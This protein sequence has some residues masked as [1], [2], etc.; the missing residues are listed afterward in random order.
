MVTRNLIFIQFVGEINYCLV[1]GE[2][3]LIMQ[4]AACQ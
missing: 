4:E 3:K 1:L 2:S